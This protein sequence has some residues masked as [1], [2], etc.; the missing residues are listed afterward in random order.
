MLLRGL[1]QLLHREGSEAL[2]ED[3]RT[4]ERNFRRKRRRVKGKSP[5]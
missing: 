2:Y 4:A 3:R 1:D 5:R